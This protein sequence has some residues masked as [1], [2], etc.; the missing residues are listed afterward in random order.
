MPLCQQETAAGEVRLTGGGR[1]LGKLQKFPTCVFSLLF[2]LQAL[3]SE[4]VT[5]GKDKKLGRPVSVCGVQKKKKKRIVDY[6][7]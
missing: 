1:V 7:G 2:S 3:T 5:S 6:R 4:I